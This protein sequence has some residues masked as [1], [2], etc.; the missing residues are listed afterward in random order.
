MRIVDKWPGEMREYVLLLLLHYYFFR[1]FSLRWVILSFFRFA[2]VDNSNGFHSPAA[3][4]AAPTTLSA[5]RL[6]KLK[7]QLGD[8]VCIHLRKYF[9]SLVPS[10][11]SASSSHLFSRCKAS[12][13]RV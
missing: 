10:L 4:A 13:L 9:E 6:V 7:F 12:D 8:F 5:M 3:A 2:S 11:P 1:Y